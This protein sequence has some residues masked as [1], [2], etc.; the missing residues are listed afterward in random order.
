MSV[1]IEETILIGLVRRIEVLEKEVHALKTHEILD[2]TGIAEEALRESGFL[3]EAPKVTRR[4]LGCRP[5]LKSEILEAQATRKSMA[6]CARLL[7]VSYNTL[8]KYCLLYGCWHPTRRGTR[9]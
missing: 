7:Q 4:G 6:A 2:K 5:L 8:R 1:S 3:P 9:K